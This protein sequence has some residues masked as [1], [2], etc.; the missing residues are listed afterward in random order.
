M[1]GKDYSGATK[2]SWDEGGA[3]VAPTRRL[4]ESAVRPSLLLRTLAWHQALRVSTLWDRRHRKA[5]DPGQT[6]VP[7]LISFMCGSS[8]P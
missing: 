6:Q 3:Q 7:A 2:G 4:G 5:G 8:S 1:K